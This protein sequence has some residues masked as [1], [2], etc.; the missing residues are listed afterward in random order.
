MIRLF[1]L[2]FIIIWSCTAYPPQ[3]GVKPL[4]EHGMY[5]FDIDVLKSVDNPLEELQKYECYIRSLDTQDS[6]SWPVSIE[7]K[8]ELWDSLPIHEKIRFSTLAFKAYPEKDVIVFSNPE[9]GVIHIKKLAEIRSYH[10]SYIRFFKTDGLNNNG[11]KM[12]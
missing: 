12:K 4:P 8:Q 10:G 2:F 5:P 11:M 7:V 6:G 1:S 3:K 9:V